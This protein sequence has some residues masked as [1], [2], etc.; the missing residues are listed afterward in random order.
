MKKSFKR[1]GITEQNLDIEFMQS[2]K[3]ISADLLTAS[4]PV[5]STPN[6]HK[7]IPGASSPEG[8]L[9]GSAAYWKGKYLSM[10][11]ACKTILETP[12]TID[13]VPELTRI[14]KFKVKKSKNFRITQTCGSLAAK[15]ILSKKEELVAEDLVKQAAVDERK[16]QKEKSRVAFLKCKDSCTCKDSDVCDAVGLKQCPYCKD[17]MRSQCSK[18]LCR[19][20]A[21][22]QGK[23]TMIICHQNAKGIVKAKRTKKTHKNKSKKTK[24]EEIY[25]GDSSTDSSDRNLT[26]DG[27]TSDEEVEDPSKQLFEFWKSVSP[28]AA[29]E[30]S[31]KGKWFAAIYKDGKKTSM[32]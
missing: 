20:A 3:F 17:V 5:P 13:E 25:N 19:T 18:A 23:P 1:C 12:I 16:E 15:D 8:V 11:D 29:D 28:P 4:D 24:Y 21:G 26:S 22:V 14:E 2:D 30:D 6:R 9:K 27:N 10:K 32:Y 31:I 7:E